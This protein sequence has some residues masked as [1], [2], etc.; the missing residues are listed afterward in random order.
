[1]A[2]PATPRRTS[3]RRPHRRRTARRATPRVARVVPGAGVARASG[4]GLRRHG[5]YLFPTDLSRRL[6]AST[7]MSAVCTSCRTSGSRP[8]RTTVRLAVHARKP[9]STSASITKRQSSIRGSRAGP[10][11]AV[12]ARARRL[13]EVHSNAVHHAC[14]THVHLSATSGPS[15]LTG[16]EVD[17]DVFPVG[18]CV[19]RA[20]LIMGIETLL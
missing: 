17:S 2:G 7:E 10:P 6:V 3:H 20:G 5:A 18:F 16:V 14:E 9:A 19:Q 12:S 15:L 8:F 4:S 1:V 13:H 11:A